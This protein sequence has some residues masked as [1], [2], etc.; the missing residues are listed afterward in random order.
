MQRIA[1]LDANETH[2]GPFPGALVAARQAI[3]QAHRYPEH[4]L[5]LLERL[6]ERHHVHEDC[7]VVAHGADPLIGYLA[8]VF[9]DRGDEAVMGA[10]SFVSYVQ[11]GCARG[12]TAIEVPVR[13]D[14]ALDLEAMAERVTERTRLVFVCNPNNPT[15]GMLGRGGRS[16]SCWTRSRRR[17]WSCSTR[18]TRSTSTPRTTPME[19]HSVRAHSN[20][21]VLRTFSKLFGLAGLRIGYMLGPP[22][23]VTA[24]RR[25]RHWYDVTDAAHLAALASL[26]EP[27][28]VARR[29]AATRIARDRLVTILAGHD[30]APLPSEASFVAVRV[31]DAVELAGLL[32]AR[33]AGLASCPLA[34]DMVRISVGD[35][36]DLALLGM[37]RW[38]PFRNQRARRRTIACD[39][40]LYR[41]LLGLAPGLLRPA[42]GACPLRAVCRRSRVAVA[43]GRRPSSP[44]VSR[45]ARGSSP[46]A[47]ARRSPNPRASWPPT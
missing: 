47:C 30:L 14:G 27:G 34:G 38:Q 16:R 7:L 35:D 26:S 2:L 17:S 20:V 18:R 24:V 44:R 42:S 33:G 1:R 13:A 29:A 21:V 9:L 32:A 37:P 28:E 12:G 6:A 5:L 46:G 8:T 4:G 11:D 45:V 22:P 40:G 41:R 39:C 15:G 10:P 31:G 19:P 23:V 36:A 25:L 43:E 3:G